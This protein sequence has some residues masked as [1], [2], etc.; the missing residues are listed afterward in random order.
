[1]K[2]E[3]SMKSPEASPEAGAIIS[4]ES[5]R[6]GTYIFLMKNYIL[7]HCVQKK[8]IF[9]HMKNLQFGAALLKNIQDPYEN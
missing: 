9:F 6:K 2:R 5:S 8:H 1:M 3:R 4:A 7:K